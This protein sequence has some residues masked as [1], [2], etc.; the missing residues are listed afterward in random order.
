[1]VQVL[2]GLV[3]GACSCEDDS[4]A[5]TIEHVDATTRVDSGGDAIELPIGQPADI[6]PTHLA[7]PCRLFDDDAPS[8]AGLDVLQR[9]RDKR[10]GAKACTQQDVKMRPLLRATALA[11]VGRGPGRFRIRFVKSHIAQPL[12]ILL[13]TDGETGRVVVGSNMPDVGLC[14]GD[15]VVCV[16]GLFPE[17]LLELKV[18]IEDALE[19]DFTWQRRRE[20]APTEGGA[21]EAVRCPPISP[22]GSSQWPE[23]VLLR[24]SG[25]QRLPDK[26]QSHCVIHIAKTSLQ[27]SFFLNLHSGLCGNLP[28]GDFAYDHKESVLSRLPMSSTCAT[29]KTCSSESMSSFEVEELQLGLVAVDA[30][31]VDTALAEPDQ[32]SSLSTLACDAVP[33]QERFTLQDEMPQY[34]LSRGDEL[35]AIN[36]KRPLSFEDCTALLEG[37]MLVQLEF[38][39]ASL[40]LPEKQ[41]LAVVE[42]LASV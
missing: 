16:N 22:A 9:S 38:R 11:P 23:L 36:G 12:G 14:E 29:E 18:Y 5:T 37:S 17:C 4:R 42:K 19:I 2:L 39:L 1:M 33:P 30:D 24:C 13:T 8:N 20:F 41:L 21:S 6:G 15:E 3:H 26:P 31:A 34:G 27:Q 10:L 35:L 32:Q 28:K 7:V 25:L 40:A